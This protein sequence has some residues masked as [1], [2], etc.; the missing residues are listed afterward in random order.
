MGDLVN[1][2]SRSS[3]SR[4]LRF[5][6]VG[7]VLWLASGT[8][9]A[10]AFGPGDALEGT[11]SSERTLRE[12]ATVASA[13]RELRAASIGTDARLSARPAL[14]YGADIEDPAAVDAAVALDLE[15]GWRYDRAA[16]L[17]DTATLLH[18][19]ERLRH[20][21]RRDVLDALR[22]QGRILTAEV[23][24]RRAELD[25]ASRAPG[26]AAAERA[27]AL[28]DKRRHVLAGLQDDAQ[29]LGFAGP[30]R[31]APVPFALPLA[32]AVAPEHARLGL[33]LDAARL[34]RD[35]TVFDLVRDV[36][37]DAT[38]ESKTDGYQLSA[39]LGLDRGRPAAVLDGQLGPQEDDQWS[40]TLSARFVVDAHAGDRRP[41]AD[42]GVRRAQAALAAADS[43]YPARV[44]R[45]RNQVD[46]ARALLEAEMAAWREAAEAGARSSSACMAWLAR[47]NAVYGAWLDVVN[48]TFAYLEVVDGAWAE[49]PEPSTTPL[50]PPRP[51]ACAAPPAG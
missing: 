27:R 19:R 47:E 15:L 9:G 43:S 10:L 18:A 46:D 7:A 31:F 17:A 33:E 45:A 24:L 34:A 42:E 1:R 23:A 44:R 37:L 13:E 26:S 30:A 41:A 14:S 12:A 28:V 3:R 16:V 20:W 35:A 4:A 36:S 32:G 25:L 49:A 48:A 11:P 40:L 39:S 2:R 6:T 5:A 22:L 38:Y 29:A 50:L 8:S 51:A 21:R